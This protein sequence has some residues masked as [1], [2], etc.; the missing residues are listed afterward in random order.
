MGANERLQQL[1]DERDIL[2][3]A[4]RDCHITDRDDTDARFALEEW[5]EKHG[6]ELEA[7]EKAD[8]ED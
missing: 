2:W 8:A 3:E 4:L 1:Q 6:A 7:L 5:D